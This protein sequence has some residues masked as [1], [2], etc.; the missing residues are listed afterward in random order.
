MRQASDIIFPATSYGTEYESPE[1]LVE[2]EARCGA[3]E[4]LYQIRDLLLGDKWMREQAPTLAPLYTLRLMIKGYSTE[5]DYANDDD[6]SA[7]AEAIFE[8]NNTLD[9]L[10]S[11]LRG[12]DA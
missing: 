11:L 9:Q 10:E 1:A 3:V 8:A 2:L 6:V 4:R 5:H 7:T 12:L